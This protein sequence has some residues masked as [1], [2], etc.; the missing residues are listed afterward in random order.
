[1]QQYFIDSALT[2]GQKIALSQDVAHHLGRVLRKNEGAS[3][4]LVDVRGR[5]FHAVISWQGKCLFA[6]V[7]EIL[8]ECRETPAP[9]TLFLSLIK[10]DKWEYSLQKCT[11]LGV[12]RLIGVA[13]ERSVVS[14]DAMQKRRERYEKILEEAAEQ[15]ER[16]RIPSLDFASDFTQLCAHRCAVNFIC[17]ERAEGIA[18]LIEALQTTIPLAEPIPSIGVFV[19]PEGGFTE[20]EIAEAQAAGFRPVTLGPRIL[21]AETAAST[22]VALIAAHMERREGAKNG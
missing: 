19:G 20:R 13:T 6:F 15:S 2:V 10:R 14:F 21:R 9:I 8:A 5:A 22:A 18:H 3:I 11:E 7:N 12:T 1:M 17:S 4:R 16:H